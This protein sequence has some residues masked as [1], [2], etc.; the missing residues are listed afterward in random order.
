MHYGVAHGKL[1][2][3]CTHL[4]CSFWGRGLA[5]WKIRI[6]V[7]EALRAAADRLATIAAA[8]AVTEPNPGDQARREQIGQLEA[9]AAQGVPGLAPTIEALRLELLAP[10]PVMSANWAGYRELLARPGVLEA[11]TAEELRAVVLELV[12]EVRYV[13]DPNRVEIILRGSSG[14]DAA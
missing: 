1:R 6:Q 9:L 7:I 13:G 5:E 8:P 12:Q 14:G 3:K 10:P 2:L 11:A 4:H